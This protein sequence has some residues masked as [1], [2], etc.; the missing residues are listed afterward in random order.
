ML[1]L[2]SWDFLVELG[3]GRTIGVDADQ[4]RKLEGDK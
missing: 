3:D 2:A 1:N 4:V